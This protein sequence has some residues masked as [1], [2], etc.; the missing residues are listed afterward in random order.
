[1][2]WFNHL[3]CRTGGSLQEFLGRVLSLASSSYFGR[4]EGSWKYAFLLCSISSTQPSIKGI[5]L[6]IQE[7]RYASYSNVVKQKSSTS[8]NI[9]CSVWVL[10]SNSLI[11]SGGPKHLQSQ[12]QSLNMLPSWCSVLGALSSDDNFLSSTFH[13][14][15]LYF[16]SKKHGLTTLRNEVN[17]LTKS[18]TEG[19][20]RFPFVG[21]DQGEPYLL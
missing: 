14:K 11:T 6:P 18:R 20:G 21:C 3:Q 4:R 1:M 8:V 16:M 9:C 13:L 19:D 7:W 17:N 12:F 15:Q 5:H 10:A 2:N